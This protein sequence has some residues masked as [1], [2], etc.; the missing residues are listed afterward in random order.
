MEASH[1]YNSDNIAAVPLQ[2]AS[3]DTSSPRETG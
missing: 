2:T 1:I 3:S